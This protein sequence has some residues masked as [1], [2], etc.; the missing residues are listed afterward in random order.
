VEYV[1]WNEASGHRI[2]E[3]AK[4]LQPTSNLAM[5]PLLLRLNRYSQVL[6]PVTDHP[7]VFRQ[8]ARLFLS[9]DTATARHDRQL[10]VR[11]LSTMNLRASSLYVNP[12]KP[13]YRIA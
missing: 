10:Y 4:E 1:E 9:E 7:T 2:Q 13:T 12:F 11:A 5:S 6:A 3:C 8:T